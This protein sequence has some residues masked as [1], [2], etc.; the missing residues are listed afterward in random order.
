V[1]RIGNGDVA[2]EVV[3]RG[4]RTGEVL[5]VPH[6]LRDELGV[7]DLV[8]DAAGTESSDDQ[9]AHEESP[10]RGEASPGARLGKDV[11]QPYTTVIGSSFQAVAHSSCVRHTMTIL[12]VVTV[13]GGSRS[14]A[15]DGEVGDNV[16]E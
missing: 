12:L 9:S 15:V 13:A 3:E 6:A 16:G 14:V 2:V 11:T 8:G 4:D 1:R 10:V 7:G 5:I